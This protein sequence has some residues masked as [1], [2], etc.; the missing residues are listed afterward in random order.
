MASDSSDLTSWRHNRPQPLP[1]GIDG[2]LA[3]SDDTKR[4]MRPIE[5]QLPTPF[6]VHRDGAAGWPGA[7][8]F[9]HLDS[10][11]LGN[12]PHEHE[13][14]VL[15]HE[16]VHLA[17][18]HVALRT[19]RISPAMDVEREAEAVSRQPVARP[20]RC[21]ADPAAPHPFFPVLLAVGA[22]LFVLLYPKPANAP[23]PKDKVLPAPSDGKILGEAI[24]FLAV[25]GGS[26]ALGARLGLGF[27]GKSALAGAA[28]GVALQAVG[29]AD[30]GQAASP[31]LYLYDAAT[32]AAIG[33][34]VPGGFRLIGQA[35]TRAFDQLA[36]LGLSQS[37]IALTKVLAERAAQAPLTAA[38]AQ[39]VL[40]SRGMAAQVSK[41]WLDRRNL[42]V[43]YRGQD[44]AAMPILSPFARTEGAAGSEALLARLRAGGM[45]DVEIAN[46]SARYH[47][48]PYDGTDYP[49]L[50][51]LPASAVGIPTTTIPGI[52]AGF[53]E[54]G[55]IYIL[56]VP[57]SLVVKPVPWQNLVQEEERTIFNAVPP[58]SVVRMV[59][60]RRVAPLVVDDRGLLAPGR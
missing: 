59:P 33:F 30:R 1:I 40:G 51:G 38:E 14:A 36:T 34:I 39:Q 20:V 53:A 57:K 24:C 17:Q 9:A 47:L 23:G 35:G 16:L 41:W 55:V 27:L 60:A 46:E 29:D 32:G 56:R 7:A 8:A 2:R 6:R 52:A 26:M 12:V 25:P 5:P 11:H 54:D 10:I 21:G 48:R 22:G 50:S 43:L 15:R 28:T 18:I 44:I 49:A 13:Q 45:S 3:L 58:G 37:D 31:L 4:W 42:I 19:G